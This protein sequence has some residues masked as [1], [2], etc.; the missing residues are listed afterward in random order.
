MHGVSCGENSRRHDDV[1]P[2]N[3]ERTDLLRVPREVGGVAAACAGRERILYGLSR[4]P[5]QRPTNVAACESASGPNPKTKV[6]SERSAKATVDE[7][8]E[9]GW[10]SRAAFCS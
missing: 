7:S 4:C 1:K 2:G 3:A 8:L 6:S 10:F 5:Q 9:R